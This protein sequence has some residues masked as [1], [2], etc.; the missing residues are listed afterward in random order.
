MPKVHL[1]RSSDIEFTYTSRDGVEHTVGVRAVT[2]GQY[3]RALQCEAEA[4]EHETP[5]QAQDRLAQ[6]ARIL[7]GESAAFLEELDPEQ[8]IEVMQC[9]LSVYAGLD[10]AA[11]IE[12][13]RALKKKTLLELLAAAAPASASASATS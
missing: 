13:Q 3:R 12:V 11:V 8:L 4:P 10:P 7:C 6:Q 9:L 2:L 5:A 1:Q